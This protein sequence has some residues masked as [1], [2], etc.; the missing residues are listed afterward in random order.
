MAGVMNFNVLG[1]KFLIVKLLVMF[2]LSMV[3][4]PAAE[5]T[6]LELMKKLEGLMEQ[7]T[8]ITARVRFVQQRVNQGVK[9]TE[10]IYFRRD[11]DD[12][13]LIIMTAPD[14]DKGNGY[15]RLG[16]NFWMYRRNTRTFQHINRDETI[17]GT[18]VKAGDMEKKKFTDQYEPLTNDTHTE[19]AVKKTITLLKQTPEVYNFTVVAKVRDVTYPK[20]EYWVDVNTALPLKVQNFSKSGDLMQT[21]WYYQYTQIK[22]KY[23]MVLSKFE[24]EFEKGNVTVMKLSEI[25][26]E[27]ISDTVFTKAYLENASR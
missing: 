5:P 16:D 19:Y 23:V 17:S 15:L 6:V 2:L 4:S 22:G 14:T 27:K 24:D 26:L 21:A 1:R 12:A 9:V 25:N 8:D 11:R 18:D 10:S 13:F 20:Q 3:S 7:G